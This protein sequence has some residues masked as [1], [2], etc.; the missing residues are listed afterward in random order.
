MPVA[1]VS[2]VKEEA[3]TG[4]PAPEIASSNVVGPVIGYTPGF[5][6]RPRTHTRWLCTLRRVRETG[7]C[8][9]T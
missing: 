9:R 8:S 3:E 1:L 6:R 2:D 4:P 7:C 5:M